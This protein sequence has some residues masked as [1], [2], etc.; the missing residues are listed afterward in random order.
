MID[1]TTK[2][3]LAIIA[4][5]VWVNLFLNHDAVSDIQSDVSSMQ[6][7]VSSMQND[8]SSIQSDVSSVESEVSSMADG[9]CTNDRICP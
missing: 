6:V 2:I 3:L 8:I 5:G 9:S 1:R 4:L 7:D